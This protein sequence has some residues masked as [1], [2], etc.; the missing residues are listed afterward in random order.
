MSDLRN[1]CEGYRLLN[2]PPMSP[3]L[4]DYWWCN[5]PPTALQKAK[6]KKEGVSREAEALPP[7][8]KSDIPPQT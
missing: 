7:P 3:Y 6:P 1:N 2:R 4:Y 5:K 8:A